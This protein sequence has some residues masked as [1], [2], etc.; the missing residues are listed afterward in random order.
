M[1][2][3]RTPI[4]LTERREHVLLL[5]DRLAGHSKN[6]ITLFGT[7][8][9]KLR[10]ET[11]DRLQ[12]IP[13]NEQL[14]IV[15]TGKYVGEGFDYPR[16]DTLFLALPIAWKGK[17]AQYAGRL[18]RNY[19]GK[20]EVQ[21]YD[22]VDIYV[23]VL[24]NMY[25]KRLKGYSAIG[26]KIK[27]DGMPQANPDLIYDGKSFYPVFSE[28]IRNAKSEILIVSP[29]MRKSRITQILRLLSEAM[30]NNAKIVVVT[31]PTEN[32]P[33]KDQKSVIENTQ[34]LESY[35]IK[36]RYRSG[37]HQ[38]FTV[39]DGQIVW[40]GSVNFLSFGTAEESIMRFTSHDIAGQLM[41]TVL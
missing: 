11:M 28:D 10:R 27:I 26:Y 25:Q 17:V 3:G 23:P 6:I 21:I 18:H 7:A 13:Q 16:L 40:Y 32:F 30:L 5:A 36:V 35:G 2:D 4:I 15:A 12:A 33:E 22:Y 34:K 38:K 9:A 20:N 19:P 24:E 1:A 39:I 14:V 37:F 31:R 41:D 29:F 8:S